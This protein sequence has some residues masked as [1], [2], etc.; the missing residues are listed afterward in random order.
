MPPPRV[1]IILGSASDVELA[2]ESKFAEV[3][4]ALIIPYEVSVVSAHRN[5]TALIEY[6]RRMASNGTCVFIAAAGLAAALPGTIA[7]ALLGFS[8]PVIGVPLPGGFLGGL[9]AT[10]AILQM[11]SGVPV[12]LA[13]SIGK[14]GLCNAAL[15]ACQM[16]AIADH[17]L[18]E[19]LVGY[20]K[21]I[22]EA[23][24]VMFSLDF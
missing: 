2:R 12:A 17:D 11:P 5:L 8:V 9:D 19:R 4:G 22:N 13:G 21:T 24:P 7:A 18:A 23:K 15:I 20:R 14:A 3:F 1:V 6:C 16:M 10:L